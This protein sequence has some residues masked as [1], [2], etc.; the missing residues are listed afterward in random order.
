ME[1]NQRET[2]QSSARRVRIGV[3]AW[4]GRGREESAISFFAL[5]FL[6]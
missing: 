4:G 5:R 6:F 3:G 2:W 1:E